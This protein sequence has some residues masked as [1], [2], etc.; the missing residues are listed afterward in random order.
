M[1]A[2]PFESPVLTLDNV[3]HEGGVE[4]PVPRSINPE[5]PL[6]NGEIEPSM[7]VKVRV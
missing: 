1:R 6:L 7:F 5:A 3:P 4:V 2:T